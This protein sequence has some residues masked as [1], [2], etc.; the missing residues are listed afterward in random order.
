[1]PSLEE[2]P[3][4]ITMGDPCGIGPEIIAKLYMDAASLPAMLVLGD[5]GLI[6]RAIGLLDLP[7]TVRIINAPEDFQFLS[8]TINVIS[9]GR[10][11]EDLPYGQLDALAGKA[12]FDYIR[13]GIDLALQQRIRAVVTAPIN[14]EALRLADIHYPG[15]TEILADF[16]GTKDFAMMLMNNDLRVI[17][18]TIHVSL[19]EAIEQLTIESELTVIRLA[20]QAMTQLGI[21]HPRIAVAGLNPHAGEHGL[22]G[23]E[24]EAIIKPAIQRAQSEGIEASGPWPGDTIF[25]HARQGRFDIVVAQYHD[26]G[27][28]P[29]KY[30]GVDEGVNVTVGL[31]FVRTSVDHGTAFDI[32]GTGKA[33]PASLRVAVEQAAMLT[34]SVP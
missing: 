31:P 15:H 25:M 12:A 29:V 3:I 32:A 21:A 28:I 14:K 7:L 17:L 2:L 10:L 8:N 30:L 16:S 6:K 11:P 4:A 26:Q 5:A 33:S 22:F 20:H 34:R 23:S 24:D 13:A 1:M 9:L 27:L 18:V 19:R